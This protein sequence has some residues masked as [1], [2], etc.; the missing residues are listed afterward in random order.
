MPRLPCRDR[1]PGDTVLLVPA[2]VSRDDPGPTASSSVAVGLFHG[3]SEAALL[4]A[5]APVRGGSDLTVGVGSLSYLAALAIIVGALLAHD[6]FLA[7]EP[8]AGRRASA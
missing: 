5:L 3:T 1:A 7:P 4:L 8:V 2:T 6:R